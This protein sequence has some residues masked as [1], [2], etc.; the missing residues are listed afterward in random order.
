MVDSSTTELVVFHMN[1]SSNR[2]ERIAEGVAPFGLARSGSAVELLALKERSIVALRIGDTGS[3]TRTIATLR[4]KS[5]HYQRSPPLDPVYAAGVGIFYA[6]GDGHLKSVGL[7]GETGCT[8]DRLRPLFW[9]PKRKV[10]VAWDPSW[11]SVFFV[12][13]DC[14]AIGPAIRLD[15]VPV[16]PNCDGDGLIVAQQR[17]GILY[18]VET[19]TRL[20]EV[21]GD[22]SWEIGFVNDSVCSVWPVGVKQPVSA[23]GTRTP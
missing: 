19:R 13:P 1:A 22:R 17:I 4:E 16:G 5:Y 23:T 2:L 18:G 9:I 20:V 12:G 11:T 21:V 15:G 7:F 14:Q 6:D 10:L 8:G 3:P